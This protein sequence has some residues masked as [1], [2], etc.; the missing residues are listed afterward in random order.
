VELSEG[1]LEDLRNHY[2]DGYKF[3]REDELERCMTLVKLDLLLSEEVRTRVL[4]LLR[5]GKENDD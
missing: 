2:E 5:G 4:D 1:Y 3:G